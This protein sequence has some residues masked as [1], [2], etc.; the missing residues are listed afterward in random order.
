M[1]ADVQPDSKSV[2]LPAIAEPRGIYQGRYDDKS[3]A[4]RGVSTD[5]NHTLP[6]Y[7]PNLSPTP[8]NHTTIIHLSYIN[9]RVCMYVYGSLTLSILT[10]TQ[11]HGDD[12]VVS[13]K[14]SVGN[15]RVRDEG[16][17]DT[18]VQAST[19]KLSNLGIS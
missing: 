6:L 13:S 9:I 5:Y 2:K 10:I 12:G 14:C 17:G 16:W 4:I 15:G 1:T 3:P 18:P 19:N 11:R 7:I 8:P